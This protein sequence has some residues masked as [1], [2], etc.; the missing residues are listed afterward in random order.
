MT[1]GVIRVAAAQVAMR[2][3]P[4]FADF[5][6]Q[7]EASACIAADYGCQALLLPELFTLQLVAQRDK[8]LSGSAAV[9]CLSA[10]TRAYLDLLRGLATRWSLDIIGGSHIARDADGVVRNTC[11]IALRDG[12]LHARAKLHPTPSERA[13]WGVV[14]GS[15][16]EPIDT[17][18]GRIGVMVCYD[19]EFPELGRHLTDAG[20]VLFFVPYCTDDRHGYLRV[21]YSCQ[22][23]AVENQCCL[24]LAGTC[25]QVAG[26]G[27][28]DIQYAQN[29]VLTPCD[30]PFARDG[31]A[32]E[33]T[34]NVEQVL[35]AE[36]DPS[37]LTQARERGTVQNLKDRRSDLY[38][39]EWRGASPSHSA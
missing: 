33:A 24:V 11:H 21:R 8:P 31:I 30:L 13:F 10:H 39:V 3:L 20:A 25:G 4:D 6:A 27:N 36:L 14:G 29:V 32:A 16:A 2:P 5:A 1:Q 7:V 12:S 18:F 37:R 35:V 38:R 26:I 34:P 9:D 19:S 17:A 15:S 28:F 23:R 22:A